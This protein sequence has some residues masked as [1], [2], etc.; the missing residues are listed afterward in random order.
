MSQRPGRRASGFT[1]IELLIVMGL[2]AIVL[3]LAAPSF[4]DMIEMQRLR[5][6]SA[7]VVTDIQWARSE[8]ASRQERTFVTFAGNTAKSCYIIHT[9]GATAGTTACRCNCSAT[10]NKCLDPTFI[11]LRSVDVDKT[12]GVT[13]GITT[14]P[15]ESTPRV[16]AFDPA[17]GGLTSFMSGATE[18]QPIPGGE[19]WID[20][21]LNRGGTTGP[22]LRASI[23]RTGRPTVCS[24][25]GGI[26]GT[27]SC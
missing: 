2:V 25:N 3:T 26:S 1:L 20:T 27:A 8:A 16:F 21:S 12:G 22:R 15:G 4:R 6:T 18:P 5:A 11:E 13:V 23:N 14:A 9:C 19:V 7:Q 17:T 24:V 10:G